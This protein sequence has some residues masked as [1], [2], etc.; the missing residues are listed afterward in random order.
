MIL[1]NPPYIPD[2]Q[3]TEE[4]YGGGGTLGDAILLDIVQVAPALLAPPLLRGGGRSRGRR[5]SRGVYIVGNVANIDT[6]A[7]RVR[8]AWRAGGG[9][10]AVLRHVHGEV[11]SA[12]RYA[13]GRMREGARGTTEKDLARSFRGAGIVDVSPQS[14]L[15]LQSGGE[16]RGEGGEEGEEGGTG[17]EGGGDGI[18][19]RPPTA[20]PTPPPRR[21]APRTS[22][23]NHDA[24]M[25]WFESHGGI[26]H[27]HLAY[28]VFSVNSEAGSEERLSTPTTL[29]GGGMYATGPIEKGALLYAVPPHL[30]LTVAA[31]EPS[32][33][34]R[35]LARARW[36]V[37]HHDDDTHFFAPYIRSLDLSTCV[38]PVC[39]P[40]N[41]AEHT[42]AYARSLRSVLL[43]V[44]G[45]GD[46]DA[47]R[48]AFSVVTSRDWTRGMVPVAELFNHCSV[49]GNEPSFEFTLSLPNGTFMP[50]HQCNVARQAYSEGEQVYSDYGIGRTQHMYF[51]KGFFPQH[52][53]LSSESDHGNE[54]TDVCSDAV[55]LRHP[56]HDQAIRLRCISE[57]IGHI[58]RETLE[59]ERE[60]E[61]RTA[62][63][64]TGV[65]GQG[66]RELVDTEEVVAEVVE[67]MRAAV[68]VGD[69]TFVRGA[70]IFLARELQSATG[71]TG[72]T[73][74]TGNEGNGISS[75]GG[76][77]SRT[78]AV[79]GAL[80][81]KVIGTY[82][83]GVREGA[84]QLLHASP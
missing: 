19:I 66:R 12:E 71:A 80:W 52:A 84:L 15:F 58:V 14:F 63:Q 13:A 41:M 33:T 45:D 68:E 25:T 75:Q 8:A 82:G 44:F 43:D 49:R 62:Q 18:P 23:P 36:L 22:S 5:G 76:W 57:M 29:M 51:Q 55:L 7:A 3:G 39:R 2:P 83:S 10:D 53:S 60:Q 77:S 35:A 47:V 61:A 69:L 74:D 67:E 73:L 1:A 56:G 48:T 24:L 4:L 54:T 20:S 65:A 42:R 46:S 38:T 32:Y 30:F 16:G 50:D 28:R 81:H 21:P 17:G 72:A 27:P 40:P 31:D 26:L 9:G 64:D 70:A 11:W 6:V 79:E 37:R 34:A 59:T 78:H